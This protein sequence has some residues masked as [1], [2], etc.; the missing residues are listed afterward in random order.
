MIEEMTHVEDMDGG[1]GLH[2]GEA[3]SWE[4][5][6]SQKIT[7]RISPLVVALAS[8]SAVELDDPLGGLVLDVDLDALLCVTSTGKDH[9]L[10]EEVRREYLR[11]KMSRE[12]AYKIAIKVVWW[13]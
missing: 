6:L 11:V 3:T 8:E 5:Q 7:T 2:W 1:L 4:P 12:G 13:W 10:A 9:I